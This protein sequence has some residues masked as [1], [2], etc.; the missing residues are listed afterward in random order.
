MPS[1]SEEALRWEPAAASLQPIPELHFAQ[2][3]FAGDP[4]T[5][6]DAAEVRRQASALGRA[7][8]RDEVSRRAFGLERPDTARGIGEPRI[9]SIRTLRRVGPDDQVVFDLVAEITQQ[10]S[11]ELSRGGPRFP[12]TGG[13]TVIIGPEGNVRHTIYKRAMNAGRLEQQR[14]FMTGRGRTYW[15]RRGAMLM[16]A[17]APFALLHAIK[18]SAAPRSRRR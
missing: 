3:R 7:A 1:L 11:V 2:L 4:A 12:F 9:D 14:E 8:M 6:A 5:A 10:R 16:A 17:E 18:T 15:K 13:A